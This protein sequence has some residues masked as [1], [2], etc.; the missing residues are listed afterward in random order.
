MHYNYWFFFVHVSAGPARPVGLGCRGLELR[1]AERRRPAP[2]CA[3]T[4]ASVAGGC[5]RGG[6]IVKIG[7]N[8]PESVSPYE[9]C[10]QNVG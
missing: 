5:G 7:V 10:V 2:K 3:E 6:V 8:L 4:R 9:Q 1:C